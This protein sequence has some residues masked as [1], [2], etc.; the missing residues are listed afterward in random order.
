MKISQPIENFIFDLDET[1]Y[2]PNSGIWDLIGERIFAF[3][4]EH[5]PDVPDEAIEPLRDRLL[6]QYGTTL[7]GL[8]EERGINVQAYLDYVHDIDLSAILKPD[9]ELRSSLA[10]LR[11]KKY[12]FTNASEGHARNVLN[13]MN[14]LDLFS[15]ITDV[16]AVQPYCK[17]MPEAFKLMFQ[18]LRIANPATCLYADDNLPN[19]ATA[20]ALGMIP[21]YVGHKEGHG[22]AKVERLADLKTLLPD[23]EEVKV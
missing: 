14:L 8:H 9:E 17:P 22:F 13:Q 19:L 3:M 12:I 7:R 15:G 1:I 11:Q 10:S 18:R 16:G 20:Q 23:L 4:R 6:R 2:Q 21:L 5:L